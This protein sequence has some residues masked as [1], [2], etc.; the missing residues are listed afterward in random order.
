MG[1]LL[2][3]LWLILIFFLVITTVSGGVLLAIKQVKSQPVEIVITPAESI[4]CQ[5]QIHIGGAVSSPGYYPWKEGDTLQ[6]LL[7]S[8]GLKP[9]A[10]FNG[11]KIYV[12][13]IGETYP[14]QKININRAE[15]W[16]LQALPEIGPV[17]AQSIV[18]YRTQK[19]PFLRIEDL[20]KVEGIGRPTYDR[21]KDL[22]TTGD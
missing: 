16:L 5:G 21:I 13:E 2:D 4:R 7:Q 22:V 6:A 14:P 11:L 19:G 10:D 8:A 9:E 20:L 12:P 17:R 18:N 1:K 3:R 15:A